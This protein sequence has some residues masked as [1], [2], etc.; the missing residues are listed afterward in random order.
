MTSLRI[1]CPI[2]ALSAALAV[3]ACGPRGFA[4]FALGY[5]T[6][7]QQVD[8]NPLGGLLGNAIDVPIPL[9]VDLAAETAARDTGPAQHVHLTE[10]RL[11]ITETAEVA[12]DT[13]DFDFVDRIEIFVE[14]SQSGSALPRQRVA[15]L[16]AV[17]RGARSIS[18]TPD[19]VDL[20]DYLREGARLTSSASGTVPPDDVTF[21]GHLELAIE[22]LP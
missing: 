5:D 4:S 13:D 14:S 11:D 7:E 3:S 9:D 15:S 10:L 20:I 16:E 6:A 2:L 21:A 22:V 8:G 19:D 17:P 12:P 18:L 1:C